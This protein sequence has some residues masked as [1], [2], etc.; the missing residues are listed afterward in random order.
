[1]TKDEAINIVLDM[2]DGRCKED[3]EEIIWALTR[4]MSDDELTTNIN[5]I[6]VSLFGNFYTKTLD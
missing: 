4:G 3:K 1:M 2:L 6:D 5:N